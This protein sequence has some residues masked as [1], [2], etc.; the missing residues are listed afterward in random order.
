M[1]KPNCIKCGHDKFVIS[2]VKATFLDLDGACNVKTLQ[3]AS[4]AGV[5][6]VFPDSSDDKRL[7]KVESMVEAIWNHMNDK[8]N[9]Q[10]GSRTVRI[11]K[12]PYEL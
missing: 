9:R 12:N 2:P 6:G 11:S 4:C 7:K 5:V 3:C 10:P 1:P 8:Q